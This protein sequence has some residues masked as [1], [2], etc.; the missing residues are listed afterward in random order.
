[1][2]MILCVDSKHGIGM[3]SG[4]IPL[5]N[6]EDM[7]NFKEITT[8][9][10]VVM[11]RITFEAIGHPLPDRVNVVISSTLVSNSAVQVFR[12]LTE[13]MEYYTSDDRTLC[14]IGGS[15]LYNECMRRCLVDSIYL[16][17]VSRDY[18]CD[19]FVQPIPEDYVERIGDIEVER[20]NKRMK[21]ID[22]AWGYTIL[23]R[24]P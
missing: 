8:G 19:V 9:C 10:I 17:R 2:I 5:R 13:C 12:S 11:G 20:V 22:P 15:G 14:V 6:K 23:D 18:N 21:D 16:T 1:M 3:K 4:R 7:K 24:T